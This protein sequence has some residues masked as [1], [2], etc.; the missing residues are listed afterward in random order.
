MVPFSLLGIGAGGPPIALGGA[1][2]PAPA[3]GDGAGAGVPIGAA[4]GGA[5]AG[6]GGVAGAP[7]AGRGAAPAGG[8]VWFIMSIVPLNFGTAPAALSWLPHLLQVCAVSGFWFPQF[9]Q[10]T[11]LSFEGARQRSA[12]PAA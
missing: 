4:A 12:R 9:G 5:G 2:L 6:G 7:A 10:N 3:N 1:A 8:G 11:P